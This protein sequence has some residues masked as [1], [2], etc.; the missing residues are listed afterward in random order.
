MRKLP[1]VIFAALSATVAA[2]HHDPAHHGATLPLSAESRVPVNFPE[3]LKEHTLANMR[4][5]LLALQEIQTALSKQEYDHAAD[6]AESRLG[7]TSL[8]Q[9]GAHEVAKYMP[10]GM[11]DIGS[12]MHR[13]ASRFA[14]TA[15]D[16]SVTGDLKPA[17]AAFADVVG[18]CV[19]CHA[20]YRLK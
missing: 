20:G 14:V 3:T 17:L 10:R 18:A 4:D 7:M 15:K 16:V 19:A 2:Q 8:T 11:Q 12:T 6:L 9:H 5:H 13:G 1:I